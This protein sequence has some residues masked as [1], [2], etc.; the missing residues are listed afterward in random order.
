MPWSI[1]SLERGHHAWMA[2]NDQM[3]PECD[4][5][6]PDF[7]PIVVDTHIITI[8]NLLANPDAFL[9]SGHEV[10]TFVILMPVLREVERIKE[11][12]W[13]DTQRKRA[14]ALLR[15]LEETERSTRPISLTNRSFLLLRWQEDDMRF[16]DVN[17]DEALIAATDQ[18]FTSRQQ[19]LKNA[20]FLSNDVGLRIRARHQ[21]R[22]LRRNRPG[23]GGEW[24]GPTVY[25]TVDQKRE[26]EIEAL[27]FNLSQKV[28]RMIKELAI[29]VANGD[30]RRQGYRF[31]G[32]KRC[33]SR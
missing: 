11:E 2:A 29:E 9:P 3:F 13:S 5:E 4:I 7:T 19:G 10:G 24:Q 8:Y 17:P 15:K 14:L 23:D 1:V 12:H 20:F 6:S 32:L 27:N 25:S 26:D 18:L 22:I 28:K 30:T 31:S 16:W 21:I 33:R